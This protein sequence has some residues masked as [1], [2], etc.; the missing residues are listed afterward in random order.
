MTTQP[1]RL[2]TVGLPEEQRG[3]FRPDL[4]SIVIPVH[5]EAGNIGML[6]TETCAALR[7]RVAFEIV[8]VDDG[9]NDGTPA[10]LQV[11]AG[12]VKELRVVAHARCLGQSVA[13]LTGVAHAR[14][15]WI[16]TLDGDGQN[17]PS[18]IPRLLEALRD[19]P[20]DVRL[21]AG[22]RVRR[23]DVAGRRLASR[24]ANHIR[25]IV[26]RDGT[27]DTGCGIK[28]FER[29]A[30]LSLPAFNHMHRYLPALMQRAGWRTISVEVNHR[31]RQA[32]RSK[33]SNLGRAWVGMRD[34]LGVAWLIGRHVRVDLAENV[35]QGEAS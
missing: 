27:P 20:E 3:L 7:D 16:A 9:S 18:D 22:W 2:D 25:R 35:D 11:L 34:L 4:L 24:A 13:L 30:F 6:L 23:H 1:R 32:G 10:L 12:K 5:D 17:D 19:A 14:G 21:V 33:Y 29:A 26:L 28:L 31:G 8:C 15:R